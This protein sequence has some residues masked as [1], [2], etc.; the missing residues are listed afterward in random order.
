MMSVTAD[1][2]SHHLRE[3]ER[4][5]NDMTLEDMTANCKQLRNIKALHRRH[6]DQLHHEQKYM[7]PPSGGQ[8]LYFV[9]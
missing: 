7:A 8:I 5:C 6:A 2:M 4:H 9:V 3:S 1:S